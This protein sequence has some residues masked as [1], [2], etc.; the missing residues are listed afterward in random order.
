MRNSFP[1]ECII[2]EATEGEAIGDQVEF[3]RVM[4]EYRRADMRFDLGIDFVVEG[5]ATTGEFAWFD[6][7]GV[8]LFQGY[9][10][11]KPM[12]EAMPPFTI[13]ALR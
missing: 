9:L 4:N 5:V 8:Q 11:A 2:V 10:F 13:P 6:K 12:F 7:L 1:L 3:A